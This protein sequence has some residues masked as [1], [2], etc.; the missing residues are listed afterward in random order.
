LLPD[1]LLVGNDYGMETSQGRADAIN[2]LVLINNGKKNFIPSGFEQSGFFVPGDARALTVAN[3]N[4][5]PFLIATE[6]RKPLRMFRLPEE[7]TLQIALLPGETFALQTHADNRIER[8]EFSNGSSFLSQRSNNWF[9]S[10]K[11]KLIV[12]YDAKGKKT[13]TINPQ[14]TQ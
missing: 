10:N 9:F 14:Q 12:F 3:I 2:G 7:N 6:N 1:L 11:L 5:S 13:R 8:I 4:N